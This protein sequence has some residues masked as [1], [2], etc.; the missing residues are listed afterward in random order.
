MKIIDDKEDFNKNEQVINTSLKLN[1]ADNN[2][3]ISLNNAIKLKN[4]KNT[5]NRYYQNEN[6]EK[7]ALIIEEDN[8]ISIFN[9][10]VKSIDKII[11]QNGK[12][13]QENDDNIIIHQYRKGSFV[14]DS[15][16]EEEIDYNQ[17][18]SEA[19][20]IIFQLYSEKKNI[21]LIK[22]KFENNLSQYYLSSGLILVSLELIN[23]YYKIYM[24]E[25]DGEQNF[26]K[27]LINDNNEGQNVLEIGICIQSNPIEQISFY[28]QVFEIIEK[29]NNKK[30]IYQIMKQRKENI[31]LLCV[32]EEKLFL[33]LFLYEI[34]KKD[35]PSSNP[36]NIINKSCLTPLHVSCY[37]L[38]R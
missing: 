17:L 36:F 25:L 31:L 5:N 7:A 28:K 3:H 2:N 11:F 8:Y 22:N 14:Y 21:L 30:I 35:Y 16:N 9:D 24:N 13:E 10:V 38:S 37:Y 1:N 19:Y 32:K 34:I 29:T 26:L 12:K 20:N 27:W 18:S 6:E 4:Y 23:I 33:L 15:I